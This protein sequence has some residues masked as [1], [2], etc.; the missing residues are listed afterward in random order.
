[1]LYTRVPSTSKMIVSVTL[2]PLP[3]VP[4]LIADRYAAVRW[5]L[6]GAAGQ[7]DMTRAAAWMSASMTAWMTEQ[8]QVSEH[9][10]GN[11]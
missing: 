3:V 6:P 10:P 2:P 4:G 9:V 1:L 8:I 7:L 5:R 11:H